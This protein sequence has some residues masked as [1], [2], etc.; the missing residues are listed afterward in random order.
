MNGQR[1]AFLVVSARAFVTLALSLFNFFFH[2][3]GC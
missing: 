1:S 2:F 3:V